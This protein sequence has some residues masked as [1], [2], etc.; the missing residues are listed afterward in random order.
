MR[1]IA[2]V[3]VVLA[4]AS[5]LGRPIA[6]PSGPA[7]GPVKAQIE[8]NQQFF[9]IGEPM[10]VRISVSNG[11]AAEVANP[12][13]SALF[14]AF[15]VADAQGKRLEPAAKPSAQEPTRPAKL[16]PN[17]FYGAVVDLSQMYPQLRSKGRFSIKWSADGVSSDE[18]VVTIIP[19]FDPS[20][21]YTARVET[22]QGTFVIDLLKRTAPIAVKAFVDL[23]NAG[24]YDGLLFHEARGDQM[25]G[26]GDPTGTGR[27]Q[28]PLRFPA[29][30]AAVPIVTGTVVMKP[31]GLA[32]P[33]NSSQFVIS[34]QPQPS[35]IGQFTVMGQVIDGLDTVRKISNVATSDPP[36]FKPLKDVHTLHVTIEEKGSPAR[37]AT[38]NN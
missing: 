2:A 5:L 36:N 17:A 30:L 9:Y 11:G 6:A 21:D 7:A 10:S 35:W 24:F 3:M 26:G 14:G 37:T 34:L 16:A 38:G 19:K 28:A 22:E 20:K 33:A 18:I 32:P 8:L 13:K 4:L 23:A 31:A 15:T 1:R 25:I 27:G 12:V 29:E